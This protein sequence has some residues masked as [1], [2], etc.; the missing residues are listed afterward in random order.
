MKLIEFHGDSLR[1]TLLPPRK[2]R[3]TRQMFSVVCGPRRSP[4]SH[5]IQRVFVFVWTRFFKSLSTEENEKT[6]HETFTFLTTNHYFFYHNVT[7]IV[8]ILSI[9]PFRMLCRKTFDCLMLHLLGRACRSLLNEHNIVLFVQ[10]IHDSIFCS[11][12]SIPSD[13]EK[14]LREELAIRRALEF[15][16]EEMPSPVLRLLNSKS[17][18]EGIKRLVNTLQYPRLNKHLSYL[19]LDLLITKLFPEYI[20]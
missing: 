11:D 12:G 17:W 8:Y 7:I 15:V 10:F 1:F 13:Q 2:S 18:R 4:F 19:L 6:S 16:Q 14:S 5:R 20:T 3:A 9:L